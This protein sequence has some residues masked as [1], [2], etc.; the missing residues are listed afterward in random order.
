MQNVDALAVGKDLKLG[1]AIKYMHAELPHFDPAL[2]DREVTSFVIDSRQVTAG[3]VFFALSQPEYRNNGFNGDFGD[4]T[5]YAAR[6]LELGATA[7]VVREDRYEHHREALE[8]FEDRLIFAD[9]VIVALQNLAHGVFL[10]WNRPVV[11]ITGSAGK[12]TAKELAAHVLEFGGRK[13]LRNA[14]NYNNGLGHPLTVLRLAADMSFDMAV[15]EM[16]MSTPMNEIARLC[17]ITPPDFAVELNVLPVHLEHLGSIENIAKAKAELVE[18]MR[19]GGTA[20][21]NAD[22]ERVAGMRSLARGKV[23]TFG[24]ENEADVTAADV[25]SSGFGSTRFV[26]TTPEGSA[27]VRFPLNGKHNVLNALSAA[28]VGY[29]SGMTA[30]QVADRLCTV[31]GL[32]QRGELLR[33]AAGFTVVDDSYNSNP[34]ALLSMVETVL[35]ASQSHVRKIVVA[36][37]MLELGE[38]AAEIHRRT[39]ESI[40]IS[41]ID[42][43]IAV[44]TLGKELAAGAQQAGLE[45]VY[46]AESSETAGTLVASM[47]RSE[48]VVLIKGSRGVRV[49]RV[50]TKLLEKFELEGNGEAEE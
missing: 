36:G 14:K 35:N 5:I 30:G 27:E 33:F 15:L 25:H 11:A 3:D 8:R 32:A 50:I 22:D 4:S 17:K 41:G 18:G 42:L 28:A 37:E 2:S 49:E 6:A 34:D 20:I 47:V 44:G 19:E 45:N 26:L 16:G 13:I 38:D 9:D 1:K 31:K 23:I 7:A 43:L 21:L 12:T 39:G 48:D 46:H 40:A 10:E 24:I 29:A